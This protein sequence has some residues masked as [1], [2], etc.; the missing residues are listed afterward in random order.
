M[1]VRRSSGQLLRE[2]QIGGAVSIGRARTEGQEAE[3]LAPRD[4]WYQEQRL[5]RDRA[6]QTLIL[7][8]G[9]GGRVA[10]VLGDV[11]QQRRLAGAYRPRKWAVAANFRRD[12]P[13][14]L[15]RL[16][17]RGIDVHDI[18]ALNVP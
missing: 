16:A 3:R 14:G 18:D 11:R 2:R 4:Q 6:N 1:G 15:R 10:R 9:P 17:A 13:N 7:R 8:F 5:A 12:P